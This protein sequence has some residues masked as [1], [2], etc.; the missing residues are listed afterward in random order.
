MSVRKFYLR[1]NMTG[2]VL[3]EPVDGHRYTEEEIKEIQTK[4]RGACIKCC[5]KRY[6]EKKKELK[7]Q[8]YLNNSE[9][10]SCNNMYKNE[11]FFVNKDDKSILDECIEC[12]L[13]NNNL[14]ESKQCIDCLKILPRS[15]YH[16]HTGTTLRNQCKTCRNMKKQ[17]S[18]KSVIC[19][20]CNAEIKHKE[21]L[22]L[23][24]KTESCKKSR[25]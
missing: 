5:N 19:E 14:P 11:L 23:H 15:E 3:Q 24:Q 2:Y 8:P 21:N 9:C 12:Y 6:K 1:A 20:F 16:V 22:L 10:K 7:E 17:Q 4:Y 13:K 25:K 18:R